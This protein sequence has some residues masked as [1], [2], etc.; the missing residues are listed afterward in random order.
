MTS[1]EQG[2]QE[3]CVEYWVSMP[4]PLLPQLATSIIIKYIYSYTHKNIK[5]LNTDLH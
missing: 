2:L 4:T 5:Y 3:E 1:T